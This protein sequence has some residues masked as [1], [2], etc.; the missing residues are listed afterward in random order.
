MALHTVESNMSLL[1]ALKADPEAT[2]IIHSFLLQ[3]VALMSSENLLN[4]MDKIGNS[5]AYENVNEAIKARNK[6]AVEE[7]IDIV[8]D[9]VSHRSIYFDMNYPLH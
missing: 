7:M 9:V 1:R 2:T 4:T 8:V 3:M 5:E 6:A